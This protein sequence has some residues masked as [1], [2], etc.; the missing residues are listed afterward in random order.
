MLKAKNDSRTNFPL[1]NK[2]VLLLKNFVYL[3]I[4]Y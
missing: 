3:C 2:K 1:Q 4:N